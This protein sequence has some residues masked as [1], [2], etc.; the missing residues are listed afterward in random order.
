[1]EKPIVIECPKCE[2][3]INAQVKGIVEKRPT[4]E[5]GGPWLISLAECAKCGSALVGRQEADGGY[6]DGHPIWT[7]PERVW[8]SP[9]AS[10][11]GQI[12]YQIRESLEEAQKCLKCKAYTASV[13]MSGRA[14][15]AIGRHSN[16]NEAKPLMLGAGLQ[17]RFCA[18][19]WPKAHFRPLSEW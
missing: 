10:L 13:G 9:A 4:D 6:E 7:E 2:A 1:M 12:P 15:E 8:P 18:G 3:V 14:L 19:I 17:K 11:S 16:P 5:A